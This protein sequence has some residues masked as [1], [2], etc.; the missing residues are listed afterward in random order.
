MDR[1]IFLILSNNAALLLVL[2]VVYE[3]VYYL[4]P[5]LRHWHNA[6]TG[7]LIAVICGVLM[8]LPFPFQAG[9]IIDTRTI[10]ISVTGLAFGLVPTAI[11]VAAA[12]IVRIM[13]G[14]SGIGAGLATI[15]TSA[16][17]GLAWRRWVRP[18]WNGWQ[19][20]NV[21]AMGIAVHAVMLLCMFLLPVSIHLTVIRSIALPVMLIYPLAT[22]LLSLLLLRQQAFRQSR[23]QLVQSE[24][25]FKLLFDEAPLG[26]QSLDTNGNIL[27][28]NQQW[29]KLLGYTRG[30][31][32]GKWFGDLLSPENREA[33]LRRFP[34]FKAQGH[35][36]CE[37][38][39]LH[40]SGKPLYIAFEG[41]I[42]TDPS[43]AFKQTHCILQD[44]TSQ[45][46][47]EAALV[48]SENKY[49]GIAENMSDVVWQMDMDLNTTY[50]SPSVLKLLGETPEEHAKRKMEDKFPKET[51][52]KIQA[53]FLEELEKEKDPGADRNRSRTIEVGH[54][55]ADGS[56]VQLEINL[57][58]LRDK[59][60]K[61][62]GFLGVSRDIT[63]R[64]LAEKALEES[65]RSKSV[66]L[67]NLQGMAYRCHYDRDWTM[68]FVSSGCR[69][70]TGYAPGDLIGNRRVAFND[71]ITPEYRESLW[72]QWEKAVAKRQPF[73]SEYELV[74]SQGKRK[75]VLEIGQGV[76]NDQGNV[77]ALEGIIFDI[78][79]RKDLEDHLIFLNEH[80]KLT[81]LYN[82]EYL[83][84][85]LKKEAGSRDGRKRALI[86]I[87]LSMVALL[88]ANYGFQYAQNLINE[89]AKALSAHC[90]GNRKLFQ[91]YASRFVCYL[92]DYKDLDELTAFSET[93]A[94]TLEALFVTDR[95]SGGIGILEI[96]EAEAELDADAILRKL[97]IASERSIAV[98]HRDFGITV[99]NDKL[100]AM[101]NR[102]GTIRHALSA[103]AAGEPGHDL[104][105]Q[106]QPIL[107]IH[108]G[109]VAG[110]EALARLR[111]ESLGLVMP[112][113]F[114]PVAEKTKLI[115]PLG[116]SVFTRAFGFLA[117]LGEQ[118]QDT[119]SVSVNISAIQLLHPDF[120]DG[121]LRLMGRMAVNPGNVLI[122]ITESIFTSDYA[123]ANRSIEKLRKTGIRV[124]IDDF[125]TG[126]SSLARQKELHVDC[127]KI[128]KY[129]INQ[130]LDADPGKAITSDIISMA[131][132]LGYFVVAEG[133]EH[134]SQLSRLKDF[135]CDWMQG[136]LFAKPLD[137]GDALA[138]I[139]RQNEIDPD[140]GN[141]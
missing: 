67:S 70:L 105:L 86:S 109:R 46:A 9:I 101:V 37:Y 84:E 19:W 107:D 106:Y 124:C 50:V 28:V 136:Y 113:E 40:K 132:K 99:Y 134:E 14:G 82:R 17:I 45:K 5:R 18:K 114:I 7:I 97:L 32:I 92:R 47:T 57:S 85:L 104:I 39:V 51:L 65:E 120:A 79:D 55:K 103:A 60:G 130:L 26:Y 53:L 129:F 141:H 77:E 61:A 43:G 93:L 122:E 11:T 112:M 15:L 131:H 66:L 108:K 75:W 31:A 73:R 13:I 80:D 52:H 25:R 81:G 127:L 30:E 58:F 38:E 78:S 111:T 74:T 12:M 100:E 76:Y 94:Q 71:L 6:I 91:T 135:G 42:G 95:I 110:F 121:L 56:I 123:A 137:E 68:Q 24:E 133:V 64:R 72:A 8:M 139:A 41:S 33:F 115:L 23:Q 126:Y 90:A 88:A 128:D 10:L 116:E 1:E 96:G 3:A 36:H 59:R 2:S 35:I 125:G 29:C 87:N 138:F 20:L 89:A 83:E 44:I 22:V 102:E 98:S 62:T 69:D 118:G 119:L 21:L 4:P 117:K 34:V 27:E 16:L 63:Q 140:E 54:Y 49:R 48:E